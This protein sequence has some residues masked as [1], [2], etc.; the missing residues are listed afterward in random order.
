MLT[1]IGC[2]N[3]NRCDDGIGSYVIRKL[4]E[5]VGQRVR[6]KI[7]IFDAGTGGMDVMFQARGSSSLIIIDASSTGSD[8][9]SIFEVPGEEIASVKD[10][11]Y[12]LH[13]FRWDHALHAGKKIFKADFPKDVTVFLIEAQRLELGL[14]LTEVVKKAGDKVV[15]IL[16]A[17]IQQI[18][19]GGSN[20]QGS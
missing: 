18:P 11:G 9:G 12:N 8:P 14:E 6:R 7:Q 4:V 3:T 19:G 1:I 17:R 15:D 10:P 13:D 5:T 2:G 20:L 16:T